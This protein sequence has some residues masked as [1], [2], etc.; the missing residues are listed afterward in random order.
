MHRGEARTAGLASVLRVSFLHQGRPLRGRLPAAWCAR[1]GRAAGRAAGAGPGGP[2][3]GHERKAGGQE[4][5]RGRPVRTPRHAVTENTAL[6]GVQHHPRQAHTSRMPLFAGQPRGS[7]PQAFVEQS[8]AI[9]KWAPLAT[10]FET[11]AHR[12]LIAPALSPASTAGHLC[13]LR[14]RSAACSYV[15]ATVTGLYGRSPLRLPVPAAIRSRGNT[16]TGLYGR[17]PLR[18]L[19]AQI[20]PPGAPRGCHRPLRPV[21]FAAWA[22]LPARSTISC[23]RPL[24]PVT[25]AALRLSWC[26]RCALCPLSPASTAGHLCDL[27]SNGEHTSPSTTP[28]H[29]PPRPVTFAACPGGRSTGPRTGSVTG[30]HGRSPLRSGREERALAARAG[31]RDGRRSALGS[32]G[33]TTCGPGIA[34]P[35]TSRRAIRQRQG[36]ILAT[37]SPAAIAS[38]PLDPA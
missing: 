24:R 36:A 19:I 27:H 14:Q 17:S 26:V 23:H 38:C 1:P 4:P 16:V 7:D 21:T 18:R 6:R 3:A 30:L 29:R 22:P 5:R 34:I 12:R 31:L 9:S 20:G 10:I 28:C 37:S 25:F 2:A 15:A 13:G 32:V 35:T 33:A 11:P 8:L